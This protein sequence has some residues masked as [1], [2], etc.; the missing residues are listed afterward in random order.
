MIISGESLI[1]PFDWKDFPHQ[2]FP[3]LV[4]DLLSGYFFFFIFFGFGD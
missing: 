2:Y 1:G 3:N 4:T